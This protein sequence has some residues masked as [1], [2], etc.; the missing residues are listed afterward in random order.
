MGN[1]VLAKNFL[2]GDKWIPG[3]V[4][5]RTGPLSYIVQIR[6]GAQWRRH[7]DQL[8]D[9]S[10]VKEGNWNKSHQNTNIPGSSGE[11]LEA[12][13][14]TAQPCKQSEAVQVSAPPCN[15]SEKVSIL[16]F[17]AQEAQVMEQYP[18]SSS[19]TLDQ[20]EV[21]RPVPDTAHKYPQR[22]RQPPLRF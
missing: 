9:G 15:Q 7:A 4:V 10:E 21:S 18:P 13:Q 1:Q 14:V 22:N 8:R 5:E 17:Q 12:V 19:T 11:Q 16:P 3:V 2:D 20:S 6:T